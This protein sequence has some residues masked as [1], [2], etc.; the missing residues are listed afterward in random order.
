MKISG[1]YQIKSTKIPTRIYIGSSNNILKRWTEHL[2]L[3]T[4]NEHHSRKLQNHYNKYGKNDL[5]FSI[6]IGCDEINLIANEQFFIDSYR[7]YFNSVLKATM[8]SHPKGMVSGNKG[9]RGLFHHTE[10]HKE[11]MRQLKL[12]VPRSEETKQKLSK[13]FKGKMVGEKNPFYGKHH[14]KESIDKA[15]EKR[16]GQVAWNKG[17]KGLMKHT[18]EWKKQHGIDMKGAKN[19]MFGKTHTPEAREKIR[20]ARLKIA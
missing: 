9:K 16:K 2:R 17:K 10:E 13:F 20:Q 6:L 7:P 11:R 5:Q 8:G 14:T 15:N 1:I 18:E 19:P 3:L 4:R 12:G